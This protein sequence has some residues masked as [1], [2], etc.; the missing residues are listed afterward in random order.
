MGQLTTSFLAWML[1]FSSFSCLLHMVGCPES[2]CIK[3]VRTDMLT[4]SWS[5]G[6]N[7]IPLEVPITLKSW[8]TGPQHGTLF[9]TWAITDVI[10]SDE[11]TVGKAPYVRYDCVLAQG[12]VDTGV[13]T[14]RWPS[15]DAGRAPGDAPTLPT[16]SRRWREA[17]NGFS[18]TVAEGTNPRRHL[19]FKPPAS[20][21]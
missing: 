6:L 8:P 19:G 11:A 10:G 21:L 18:F 3:E 13:H 2:C 20:R 12:N 4:Y 5:Y 15:A 16:H 17:W 9:G 14:G 7:H 1:C